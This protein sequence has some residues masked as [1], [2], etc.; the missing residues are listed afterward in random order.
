[1]VGGFQL[2]VFLPS[3]GDALAKRGVSPSRPLEADILHLSQNH[4]RWALLSQ[5]YNQRFPGYQGIPEGWHSPQNLPGFLCRIQQQNFDLAVQ[6]HGSGII[7]GL[8]T[9]NQSILPAMKSVAS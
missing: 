6:M 7:T 9:L 8:K 5:R 4:E 3:F 1:M 2:I